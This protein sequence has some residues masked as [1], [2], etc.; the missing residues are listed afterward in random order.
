MDRPSPTPLLTTLPNEATTLK[1]VRHFLFDWAMGVLVAFALMLVGG[2]VWGFARAFQIG[3]QQAQTATAT[4]PQAIAQSLGTPGALALLAMTFFSMAPA[5]LLMYF[6]RRRAS[7]AERSASRAAACRAS[8]WWWTLPVAVAVA[9]ATTVLL[10][11][12]QYLGISANPSNEVMIH[13]LWGQHPWLLAVFVV[14]LAP[15]YEE[16]FF[17]R[18]LFGRLWQ[19]GRPWLGMLLSSLAFAL[20]HEMPGVGNNSW[21]ATLFLLLVYASMGA[22]F[23]WL[24]RRTGTL[25]APITAHAINN[26]L[27]IALLA[28]SGP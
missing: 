10:Q 27:A 6:W 24:Y 28:V 15:I 21:Q 18:V 16:L 2:M 8:T 19:A 14:L 22:T 7:P 3:M 26:G 11:L 17:R 25:W 20:A 23:A 13:Q 4:D 12:A 1:P 5:A 9:A